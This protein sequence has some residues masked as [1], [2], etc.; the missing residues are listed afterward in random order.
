M[1]SLL[2]SL[3]RFDAYFRG[4]KSS[5]LK[6]YMEC[7]DKDLNALKCDFHE[8]TILANPEI[9]KRIKAILKNLNISK[10]EWNSDF[11]KKRLTIYQFLL[12]LARKGYSQVDYVIDLIDEKTTISKLSLLLTGGGI[13]L[14]FI[15]ILL[16]T[17][18]F[19]FVLELIRSCFS[20]I[21]AVPILG[22]FYGLGIGIYHFY[23]IC[24]DNKITIVNRFRNICFLFL[25]TSA[26][27]VAS[28]LL[29]L[30]GATMN[31]IIAG[32]FVAGAGV[33]VIKEIFCLIQEYIQYKLNPP[34]NDNNLISVHRAHARR[35]FGYEK[36]ME[37]LRINLTS[38]FMI[39]AIMS[40][41]C[42]IPGGGIAVALAAISAIGLVYAAKHFWLKYNETSLREHLQEE[43]NYIEGVYASEMEESY[44]RVNQFDVLEDD[45][46]FEDDV[47]SLGIEPVPKGSMPDKPKTKINYSPSTSSL[48]GSL[49]F[50]RPSI[51]RESVGIT[52]VFY[53]PTDYS[54]DNANLTI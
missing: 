8:T 34:L 21:F 24:N 27:V 7:Y 6:H 26:K 22:L 29:I 46:L 35:V 45:E 10:A 48:A 1:N 2:S 17:S 52:S 49:P 51:E 25:G 50:F 42:F 32:V 3:D 47:D 40:L 33:D 23:S 11:K 14:T 54:T 16:A 37:A 4:G 18:T 31:P 13:L 28:F 39:V 15:S 43:L 19:H 38:A 20:S 30:A 53:P 5:D 41:W 12:I 36:R 9:K 44:S